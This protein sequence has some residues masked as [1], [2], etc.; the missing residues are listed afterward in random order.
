MRSTCRKTSS[1][2]GFNTKH[3]SPNGDDLQY[4]CYQ[5]EQL[6]KLLSG[7]HLVSNMKLP[8]Q[9]ARPRADQTD[10]QPSSGDYSHLAWAF[11]FARIHS[12]SSLSDKVVSGNDSDLVDSAV[13]RQQ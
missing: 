4:P 6:Q 1:P 10:N 8:L 7:E 3:K 13:T 2:L 11:R 5:S 9:F 12:Q